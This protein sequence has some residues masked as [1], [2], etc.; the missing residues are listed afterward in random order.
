MAD[1]ITEREVPAPCCGEDVVVK[2]RL[3]THHPRAFGL[4]NVVTC[5]GCGDVFKTT[6]FITTK[7]EKIVPT[8]P[9]LELV[10]G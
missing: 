3:P 8:K 5:P 7:T 4:Q 9:K 2:V 10:H 1:G 6:V